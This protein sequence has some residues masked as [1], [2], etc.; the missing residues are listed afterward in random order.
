MEVGC[1]GRDRTA[2]RLEWSRLVGRFGVGARSPQDDER[3]ENAIIGLDNQ[4]SHPPWKW[5]WTVMPRLFAR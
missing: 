2:R 4:E 5:R 1:F 3:I